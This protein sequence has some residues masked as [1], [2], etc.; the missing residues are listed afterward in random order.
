VHFDRSHL[1]WDIAVFAALASLLRTL[2]WRRWLVL[3]LGSSLAISMGVLVLPPHFE[4]YRGLSGLDSAL[5]AAA[6]ALRWRQA[7]QTHDRP[8]ALLLATLATLF[9]AKCGYETV[10]HA[11]VFDDATLYT[12]APIA[13][14]IGALT[15][16]ACVL[17]PSFCFAPR[18]HP[19]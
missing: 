12:P 6:L 16:I 5:F 2:S 9:L 8:A 14:L 3:L 19:R 18:S 17:A 1:L 7:R 11:T 4:L 15:G 13:H 10:T